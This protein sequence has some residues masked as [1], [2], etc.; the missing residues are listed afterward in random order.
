MDVPMPTNSRPISLD[1]DPDGRLRLIEQLELLALPPRTR[2]AV[3]KRMATEIR[4]DSRR[5]IR[6]QSTVHGTA[7]EKRRGTRVRRKMLRGLGK[8]MK[9]YARG[10]DRAEVTW[11][12]ALT[13]RIADRHQHGGAEDWTAG[14]ARKVY[15]VPDYSQPASRTQAKALKDAGYRLRVRRPN[16]KGCTLKRVP[17]KWICENLSSGQAGVI[18]RLLRDGTAKGAR[19]WTVDTPARPFLGPK[20]GDESRLLNDL[21]KQAL[22]DIRNR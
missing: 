15:G 21:A 17:I 12:N 1:T 20:P 5:N 22:S 10:S 7:M 4:K 19:R 9:I 8:S 16:G 14:K 3:L 6:A 2:R 13:A 18:L 11:A